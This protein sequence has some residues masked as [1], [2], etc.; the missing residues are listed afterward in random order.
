MPEESNE[1]VPRVD[2]LFRLSLRPSLLQRV[3]AAD[4]ILCGVRGDGG[5]LIRV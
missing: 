4:R 1:L 2:V 3:R 5:D